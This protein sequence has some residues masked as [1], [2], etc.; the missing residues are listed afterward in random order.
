MEELY[1]EIYTPEG[2][3]EFLIMYKDES[4]RVIVAS[5]PNTRCLL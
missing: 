2:D 1:S 3:Y 5:N 4:A